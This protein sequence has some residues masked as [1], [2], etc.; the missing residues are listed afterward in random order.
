MVTR[1][2]EYHASRDGFSVIFIPAFSSYHDNCRPKTVLCISD[3][4]III[5]IIIFFFFGLEIMLERPFGCSLFF[6]VKMSPDPGKFQ[7]FSS[8]PLN[9]LNDGT[10]TSLEDCSIS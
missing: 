5:V 6:S 9:T 2:E 8:L 3:I 7:Y 4:I 10:D 1:S